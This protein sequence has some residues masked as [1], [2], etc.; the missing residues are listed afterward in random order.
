VIFEEMNRWLNYKGTILSPEPQDQVLSTKEIYLSQ[1]N[2][3]QEKKRN[4]DRR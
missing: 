1:K 2:N 4:R 3:V